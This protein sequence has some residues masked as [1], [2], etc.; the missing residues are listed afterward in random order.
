M[1]MSSSMRWR[2]GVPVRVVV[3]MVAA[4]VDERGGLPRSPTSQNL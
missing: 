3:S 4:P 2:N 1:R